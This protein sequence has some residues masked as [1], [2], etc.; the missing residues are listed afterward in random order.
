M[1]P[2]NRIDDLNESEYAKLC[3]EAHNAVKDYSWDEY[4]NKLINLV[5]EKL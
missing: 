2:I 3:E 5:R 1:K 4:M